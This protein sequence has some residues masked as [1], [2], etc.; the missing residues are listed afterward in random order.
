MCA[1]P[2]YHTLTLLIRTTGTHELICQQVNEI[3]TVAH[4]ALE[5]TGLNE[6]SNTPLSLSII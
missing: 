4:C 5:P 6:L 3:T 1:I 2:N